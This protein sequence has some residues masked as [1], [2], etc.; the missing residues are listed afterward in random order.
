MGAF[1][2]MDTALSSARPTPTAFHTV[3]D[4]CR[5]KAMKCISTCIRCNRHNQ[6]SFPRR[7]QVWLT[8][9]VEEVKFLMC[10][11]GSVNV[12]VN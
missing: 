12:C 8:Q 3:T 10:S 1:A 9:E 11:R 4:K 5:L 2:I 6:S 7:M